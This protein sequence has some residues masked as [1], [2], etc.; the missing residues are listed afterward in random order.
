[1]SLAHFMKPE[2][3]VLCDQCA[4]VGVSVRGHMTPVGFRNFLKEFHG[5]MA[6]E[7]PDEDGGWVCAGCRD[8]K[9]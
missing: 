4:R 7:L 9:R 8:E 3:V 6:E 2:T 5:Y 1:M